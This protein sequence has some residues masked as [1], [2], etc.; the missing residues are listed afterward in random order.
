MDNPQNKL[1][2][3]DLS[4][5]ICESR[6]P[7]QEEIE[8]YRNEKDLDKRLEL[9]YEYQISKDDL[10]PEDYNEILRARFITIQNII[11]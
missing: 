1:F 4:Y 8:E 5:R 6:K 9:A 7:T 11:E 10:Y 3:P 2:I